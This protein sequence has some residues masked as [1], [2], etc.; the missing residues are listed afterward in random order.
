MAEYKDTVQRPKREYGDGEESK[1]ATFYVKKDTAEDLQYIK[2]VTGET[3][4]KILDR[5]VESEANRVEGKT[6]G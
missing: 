4:G 5:L 6:N 3:K 2:Q 1:Y